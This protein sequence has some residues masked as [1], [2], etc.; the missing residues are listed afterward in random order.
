MSDLHEMTTD[1]IRIDTLQRKVDQLEAN[2]DKMADLV[3]MELRCIQNLKATLA[4]LNEVKKEN[5]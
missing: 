4:E 5:A 3:L 2:M 1:Q